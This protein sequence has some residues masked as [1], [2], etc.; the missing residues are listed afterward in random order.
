MTISER[1][2]HLYKNKKKKNNN[3]PNYTHT[4][5]IYIQKDIYQKILLLSHMHAFYSCNR[6]RM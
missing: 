5:T 3:P 2:E 4:K 6:D 1:T